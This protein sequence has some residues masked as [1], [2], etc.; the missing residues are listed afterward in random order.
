MITPV[1]FSADG[2]GLACVDGPEVLVYDG[3]GRPAF[4]QHLHDLLV[5][6]AWLGDQLLTIDDRGGLRRWR[7]ADGALLEERATQTSA[8]GMA[9]HPQGSIAILSLSSV[10]MISGDA[11]PTHLDIARAAAAGFGP[12]AASLGVGD[13]SGTFWALEVASGAAWGQLAL[14][15]P[16]RGV[17]WS[18]ALTCWIVAA[19]P[20]LHRVSGDGTQIQGSLQH[21]GDIRAMALSTDGTIA[22]AL[23]PG[24]TV[25][26]FDLERGAPVGALTSPRTMEALAFGPQLQL[27]ISFDDGD[28]SLIDLVSG[29]QIRTE[30]HPGR[31]RNQWRI[32]NRVDGAS[33]RG[34]QATRQAG[35]Q[36]IARYV[37]PPTDSGSGWLGG[38]LGVATLLAVLTLTCAGLLTAIYVLRSSG[39]WELIPFR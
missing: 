11:E 24:G 38:C 35:G 19:G 1:A 21:P 18:P 10:A 25:T 26:A 23:G 34:A 3:R 31:G 20:A 14:E 13:E 39:L 28:A 37:P 22:A 29:Q 8:R 27:A 15:H 4:K 17:A 7:R 5:G 36:P 6:V 16:V 2:D 30:P 33:L 12:D 32:D 9:V